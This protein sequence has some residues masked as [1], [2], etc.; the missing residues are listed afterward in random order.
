MGNSLPSKPSSAPWLCR[1]DFDDHSHF[2][3]GDAHLLP[4]T[5]WAVCYRETRKTLHLC[6]WSCEGELTGDNSETVAIG[7]HMINRLEWIRP[8]KI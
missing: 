6:W 5:V 4:C 8:E 2:K 1:V 7:K 3:D